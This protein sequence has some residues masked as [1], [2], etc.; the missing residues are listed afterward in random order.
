VS[1]LIILTVPHEIETLMTAL[2]GEAFVNAAVCRPN[3]QLIYGASG[4][5][6]SWLTILSTKTLEQAPQIT[7]IAKA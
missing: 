3:S 6:V 1:L 4:N 7:D 2:T 5:M